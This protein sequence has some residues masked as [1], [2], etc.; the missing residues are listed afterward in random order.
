M[1]SSSSST[2]SVLLLLVSLLSIALASDSDHKYQA[3]EQVTLWV[4]KVGPYNNPQETYNYYSLPF[5]RPSQNDVHKWGGLGEVLGG[6]ELIDS[7]IPIK[8]LKDV[9]RN[10]ICKLE[11][12][13]AKV[14]HF[15][16]AIESSY[17]FEFFMDDLPLWGFVGELHLE[18]NSEN[19]KHVLYTHKNIVVKY[20]KDQVGCCYAIKQ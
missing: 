12:D 1:P 20:N 11:L 18:K 4:N 14:Q 2:V 19:A 17:W 10:V 3:E 15:K 6:N 7:E 5:C 8:F 9:D 13:E 16:D